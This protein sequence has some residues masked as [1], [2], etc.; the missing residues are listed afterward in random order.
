MSRLQTLDEAR[1]VDHAMEIFW[2][3]GYDGTSL[4]DLARDLGLAP[5]RLNLA[6]G[7]KHGLFL[8]AL[9]RYRDSQARSL[10][11]ALLAEG[12]VLPRI[13]AIMLG[14]LQLAAEE[15]EPRGCLIANTAGEALPGD[16]AVADC[17]AEVMSV[18][19]DGFLQG[20]EH[21]VQQ[22]ELP[23]GIDVAGN[24]AMLTMLLQGLQVLV[25]LDPDPLRLTPAVD[26]ALAGLDAARL[27]WA[28]PPA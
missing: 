28:R 13:R 12:L 22:G 14:Y 2:T 6:F 4:A 10:A 23:E 27:R 21:A 1:A 19:E 25:K 18:V 8:R 16:P 5:G 24:A 17:L 15:A 26:A 9:E 7:D 20:L 11:P 3:K